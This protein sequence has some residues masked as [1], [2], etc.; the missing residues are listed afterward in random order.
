MLRWR[1]F[2]HSRFIH[3]TLQRI[4][5]YCLGAPGQTAQY[6]ND[7]DSL[8][9]NARLTTHK[10][11]PNNKPNNFIDW[12]RCSRKWSQAQGYRIP[13]QKHC[14]GNQTA[15]HQANPDSG[16]VTAQLRTDHCHSTRM[17][18]TARTYS[19]NG[20]IEI[21]NILTLSTFYCPERGIS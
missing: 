5:E 3:S 15:Q 7:D 10:H 6:N 19:V 13:A 8:H 1:R 18:H 17:K 16:N 20:K 9:S 21:K 14:K 12:I 11:K 4:D 2:I